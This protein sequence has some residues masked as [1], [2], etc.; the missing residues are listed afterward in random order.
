MAGLLSTG[1]SRL[2]EID[3]RRQLADALQQS[4]ISF[5]PILHPLQGV[6]KLA[7]ALTSRSIQKQADKSEEELKAEQAKALAEALSPKFQGSVELPGMELQGLDGQSQQLPGPRQTLPLRQPTG[8]EMVQ[9]LSQV[10]PSIGVGVA[11][12]IAQR[13]ALAER[14]LLHQPQQ[15][16]EFQ[17]NL[18]LLTQVDPTGTL[19]ANAVVDKV[20]GQVVN[21]RE[22]GSTERFAG[23]EL[24]GRL[25]RV[26]PSGLQPLDNNRFEKVST[27]LQAGRPE[28][29][30]STA[31]NL[32]FPEAVATAELAF[33]QIDRLYPIMDAGGLTSG[34][35]LGAMREFAANTVA[36]FK[37][38]GE[39]GKAIIRGQEVEDDGQMLADFKTF[40]G[41]DAANV[42][43]RDR[44]K[45]TD[46][47]IRENLSAWDRLKQMDASAQ[48]ISISLA[49]TLARIADPGGRLSE[50][51]V[52][53][54]IKALQLDSTDPVRRRAALAN[55]ERDFAVRL[56]SISRQVAREQGSTIREVLGEELFERM[57]AGLNR[58]LS[59]RQ[60]VNL[61]QVFNDMDPGTYEYPPGSGQFFEV[62]ADGSVTPLRRVR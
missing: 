56:R 47:Q 19:A 40:Q 36:T 52:L 17:Q 8:D 39:T 4:A 59:G 12:D 28:D 42:T 3:R 33:D 7:Q 25:F 45:Y 46:K 18:S 5:D 1:S 31:K 54:Q 27:A 15:P 37:Q 13:Q 21:L 51:D 11:A 16:S 32:K 50:M 61:E 22:V 58:D 23:M 29:L 49:Y 2:R 34:A 44:E 48:A 24:G 26:G 57:Q 38:L 41:Y 53:N 14:G 9:G 10:D 30:G 20:G 55:A 35:P 60:S 62:E 43:K 6:A